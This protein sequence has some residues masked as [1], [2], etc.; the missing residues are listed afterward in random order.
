M[1]LSCLL[2]ENISIFSSAPRSGFDELPL[3]L[4]TFST[5]G[6]L[7]IYYIVEHKKNG[8]TF[9]KILLPS[10]IMMG[11]IMIW[12]IFRQGDRTFAT[13]D[14]T[15]TFNIT[16]T[17][18]ER[19]LAAFQ[20]VIWLGVL[21]AIVFV[22]NRYRLNMDSYRWIPKI[23][24][25]LIIAFVVIDFFYEFDII[26]GI[27]NGTYLGRGVVFI[28]GNTNVWALVIFA[29]IITALIL[30]NKRFNWYY[31]V[32]MICLFC[33]LIVT[34][35]A[36]AI[37]I[38]LIVVLAYPLYEIFSPFK[39]DKK[40]SLKLLIIY[41][42]VVL[43]LI[44]LI[45]LFINI[46]VP[47]FANFWNFIDHSV[48]HKDFLTITG[49][50]TIWSHIIELLKGNPLDFIFGLGHQTGSKIY[51]TYNAGYYSVKSAHNAVMEVFLRYG[52]I[53]AII[54]SLILVSVFICLVIHIK[55]KRYR[56]AFIYGLGYLAILAHSI[57]EST[58]I[59][60][61]NIGGVYFGLYFV[62]PLTN[63]IQEK[64]F[65]EVKDD[66]L[67]V[68]INKQPIPKKVYFISFAY[69]LLLVIVIKI[70]QSFTLI[71]I[72][73]CLLIGI[74]LTFIVLF[75]L[76]LTNNKSLYIINDNIL[77]CYK[78]R[79]EGTTK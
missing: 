6:L 33:Y 28:F 73:S 27:F 70:I 15:G 17:F 37:Y 77:S 58:T 13:W 61:P 56:L 3:Y 48:L 72:L 11:I 51:Q 2:A 19:L 40:K 4:L 12:T 34:T 79:L 30:L 7:A 45:A 9:D 76:L 66:V 35:S 8:L 50:T 5:I 75:V 39:K 42:A 63:V 32:S 18:S 69:I 57:A 1:I 21:Y 54:Y 60:T 46:G 47:I 29:G 41:V 38:S 36:T 24:L 16:F 71:D 68:E 10:F 62:L 53:G 78:R 26:A 65:K 44:G 25:I 59:F 64:R 67:S 52:L 74:D 23:F 14:N 20:V 31:F 43:S 49:R 55:R 22:Y